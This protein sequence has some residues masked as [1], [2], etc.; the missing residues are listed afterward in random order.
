MN[1]LRW[2]GRTRLILVSNREP[3]MHR[4]DPSGRIEVGIPAG[5]LTA[6]LQPLMASAG[7]TWVAWGSGSADFAV[8]DEHD[9]VQVPPERPAYRLRRLR[10]T[11]DEVRGFYVELANRSLW[12]LCHSLLHR[13]TF[14]A[15]H[16]RMYQEVNRRFAA[17]V[18]DEAGREPATVWVQDYHLALVPALLRRVRRLFV[19]QFWHIP[20][21]PPDILR[22]LPRARALVTALLGNHLLAF[23]TPRDARN[24][25]AAA[26]RFIGAAVVDAR[27]GRVRVGSQETAVRAFPISVDVARFQALAR[28]ADVEEMSRRMRREALPGGRGHLLLGVDRID[29]TKGIPRRFSAVARLFQDHPELRGRATLYQIGVP[30]RTD[31]PEYAA[32]EQE[33]TALAA[34]INARFGTGDWQ[35]IRLA[36]ESL[37]QPALTACYRAA[38]VCIVTPLLDGMNLIAKEFVASQEGKLGVL[39]L[40]RFAGSAREMRGALLVNPYDI[41]ATARALHEALTLPP[42]E[43]ERRMKLMRQRLETHT[44]Y[45]WM[46]AIFKEVARVRRDL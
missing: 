10:L 20:W 26:R 27:R 19:H 8:T 37:D 44:V 40:S 11:D 13:F 12:P 9:T 32:F 17:A 23:Q 35:P 5:G 45:D 15:A 29:Y 34:E 18:L 31:V 3:F 4:R 7:G 24:F 28:R 30:S 1:P 38:D 25:L 36:R 22:V 16:W 14:D 33:V 46:E 6:A 43:R 39:V 41:G 21:P 2:L 42:E